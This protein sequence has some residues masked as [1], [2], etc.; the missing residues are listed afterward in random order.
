MNGMVLV[1]VRKVG[2]SEFWVESLENGSFRFCGQSGDA[3]SAERM[4]S[5]IEDTK[6]YFVDGRGGC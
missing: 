4:R 1:R 6:M 3:E 2:S 5:E